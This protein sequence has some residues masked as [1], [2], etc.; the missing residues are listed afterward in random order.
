M[1]TNHNYYNAETRLSFPAKVKKAEDLSSSS[2][3]VQ[4]YRR[5]MKPSV[6]VCANKKKASTVVFKA[7]LNFSFFFFSSIQCDERSPVKRK[8]VFGPVRIRRA[9]GEPV[10]SH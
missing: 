6:A 4:Q 8:R 7:M 10:V 5:W 3:L 2:M 1:R 9:A